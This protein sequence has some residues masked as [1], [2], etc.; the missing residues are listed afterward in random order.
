MLSKRFFASTL[1]KC[2][3]TLNSTGTPRESNTRVTCISISYVFP[4]SSSRR[5]PNPTGVAVVALDGL[6]SASASS[7]GEVNN[8][9]LLEKRD[10][11][12]CVYGGRERKTEN[13]VHFFFRPVACT[14]LSNRFRSHALFYTLY[15]VV[16]RVNQSEIYGSPSTGRGEKKIYE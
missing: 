5:A 11:R 7:A 16:A 4:S 13:Y 15:I 9:D 2:V 1:V 6:R 14:N 10:K 3:Q 12:T 8:G